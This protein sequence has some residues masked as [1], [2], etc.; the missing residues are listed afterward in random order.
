MG[1]SYDSLVVRLNSVQHLLDSL[2]GLER[3]VVDRWGGRAGGE[4]VRG[5]PF[6]VQSSG[7]CCPGSPP[8]WPLLAAPAMAWRPMLHGG[9]RAH[10]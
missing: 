4:G 2:S 7:G 9:S 5:Q 8:E 3:M 1:L 6:S 10:F